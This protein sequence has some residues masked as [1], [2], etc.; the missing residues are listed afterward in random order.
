VNAH[1]LLGENP[2][3][4]APLLCDHRHPLR[5]DSLQER[6]VKFH[7][8]RWVIFTFPLTI[9]DAKAPDKDLINSIHAE[10]AFSYAIHPEV[11]VFRYALF[12]GRQLVV[13]DVDKF[14]PVLIVKTQEIE[15]K[16][17]K[18]EQT[19]SAEL[20]IN[21]EKAE[22]AADLGLWMKK[23]GVT[24]DG[25][26]YFVPMGIHDI[27]MFSIGNYTSFS[28]IDNES[29][30]QMG[31]SIDYTQDQYEQILSII[32]EEKQKEIKNALAKQPYNVQLKHPI[33]AVLETRIGELQ[34]GK[35]EDF[36]PFVV[37]KVDVKTSRELQKIFDKH[38]TLNESA[39]PQAE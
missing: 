36:I 14:E 3:L 15:S 16:W 6:W 18:V 25:V 7:F 9:I 22:F 4:H 19:L 24:I 20:V 29:E 38:G 1:A 37:T 11:R 21:P 30:Q 13:Y 35:Y 23:S 17:G 5:D 27:M 10:Q 28:V 34:H 2:N 39:V 26:Q 31:A 12:N 33:Q 32:S 8:P